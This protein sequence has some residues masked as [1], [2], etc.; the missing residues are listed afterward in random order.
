MLK[1]YVADVSLRKKLW[2][3]TYGDIAVGT[4]SGY[5]SICM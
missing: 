4:T 3:V 2:F 5:T 1:H